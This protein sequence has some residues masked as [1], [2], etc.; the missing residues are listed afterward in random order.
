MTDGDEG[1]LDAGTAD[2]PAGLTRQTAPSQL[3]EAPGW[4]GRGPA[5]PASPETASPVEVP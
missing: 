2:E 1:A 4:R 3:V 5:E